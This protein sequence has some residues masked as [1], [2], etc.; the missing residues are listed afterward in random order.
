MPSS[1]GETSTFLTGDD[2][3]DNRNVKLLLETMADLI[4]DHDPAGLVRKIVDRAI[5][6]VHAERCIL[7]LRDGESNLQVA[8]ALDDQGRDLGAKFRYSKSLAQKALKQSECLIRSIGEGDGPSDLS[9]SI[10]DLKLRAV[11]CVRLSFKDEITGVIY[12][13]SRATAR[14]FTNKDSRFFEALARAISIVLENARLLRAAL[15]RERLQRAIEL[16]REVLANLLP[17]D[18]MGVQGFDLAGLSIPAETAAGDYYDFVPC[19]DGKV[20]LVVGDV[21]GHGIGPAMVMTGAR[22]ALRIL[23]E[24]RALDE[25]QILARLNN[26]MVEDLGDGR[27]MS[28]LVGRLDIAKRVVTWANAGQNPPLLLR[29]DGRVESLAG[30]G[31]ALGIESGFAYELRSPITLKS[32]DLLLWLTDGLVEA[33]NPAGEEYGEARVV[34]LLKQHRALPSR[35]LLAKLREAIVEHA[36]REQQDDDVTLLLVRAL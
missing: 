5:K 23:F 6:A 11:M 32:G 31:L 8:V 20:G 2:R 21:T 19:P 12:V 3:I 26:R 29:A 1:V 13:D 33:R 14:T 24:D 30:A 10:V 22:S 4:S 7:L 27:F 34:A 35:Q 28:L 16:A 36:G 9:A 15:E 17:K 25:A 18:P